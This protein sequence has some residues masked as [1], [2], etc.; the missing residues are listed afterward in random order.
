MQQHALNAA[1]TLQETYSDVP[2][3]EVAVVMVMDTDRQISLLDADPNG[4]TQYN[5]VVRYA[6]KIIKL[7]GFL[8]EDTHFTR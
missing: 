1:L 5:D 2:I 8:A 7:G 3:S 4:P 6:E